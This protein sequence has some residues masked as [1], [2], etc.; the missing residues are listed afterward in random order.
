MTNHDNIE[1]LDLLALADGFLDHDPARKA[2]VEALVESDNQASLRLKDYRAQTAALRAA[3]SGIIAEAVPERFSRLIEENDERSRPWFRR[4]VA[5]VL[6]S[7]AALGGWWAGS[8]REVDSS[9]QALLDESYRQ[10]TAHPPEHANS[11]LT[12][13]SSGAQHAIGWL[14]EDVAIRLSA[15]DL[16]SEG[17]QLIDKRAVHDKDARIVALDYVAQ[18]G[19]SFTLFLAPR[20]EDRPGTIVEDERYGVALSYWHDGPLAS[21][22]ATRLPKAEARHL[23]ETVRS[24]MR[25]ETSPP[26]T[27]EPDFKSLGTQ[28]K[29]IMADT[30]DGTS[31]QNYGK[32]PGLSKG[33]GIMQ[34]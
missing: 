32:N 3:H 2:E 12:P 5:S 8:Q 7:T 11:P 9:G 33:S 15:P 14:Q 24:E 10:F 31:G 1:E 25:N 16:S 23:A 29:G 4:A 17:F 30:L 20:W 28:T 18:D 27:L 34:N 26:A 13:T 21:S 22:I 6:I 19:R